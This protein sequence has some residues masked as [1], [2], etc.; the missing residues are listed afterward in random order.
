MRGPGEAAR[1]LGERLDRLFGWAGRVPGWAWTIAALITAVWTYPRKLHPDTMFGVALDDRLTVW[2]ASLVTIA[3]MLVIVALCAYAVRT[4]LHFL[5]EER[6]P[7]RAI[8]VEMD[9]VARAHTQLRQ[10]ADQLTGAADAMRKVEGD[11]Q[12]AR[13]TILLLM[14]ELERLRGERVGRRDDPE[15]LAEGE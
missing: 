3:L 15:T 1:L 2:L 4:I 12:N 10:D 11:M 13:N 14:G 5:E 7:R 8:G 6:W 9:D